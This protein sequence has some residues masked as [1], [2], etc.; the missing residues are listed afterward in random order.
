MVRDLVSLISLWLF[1]MA[2]LFSLYYSTAMI[3]Q[4]FRVMTLG[5]GGE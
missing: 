3:E 2:V 5:L 4:L 1:S